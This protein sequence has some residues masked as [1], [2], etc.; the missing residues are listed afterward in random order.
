MG[1]IQLQF[2]SLV[3]KLSYIK[4]DLEYHRA[5]HI[6]RR[7]QFYDD[8]QEF[9]EDST[10]E[11]SEEKT[12]KNMIDVYKKR[13][14]V[15]AP[16]LLEEA[17][18]LYK[19]IAKQTHPDLY[20]DDMKNSVFLEASKA[21]DS[22]DWHTIYEIS[23]NLGVTLPNPSKEHVAWLKQEIQKIQS[24]IETI[25]TTFEWKYCMEGANKQ[26]LLTT[27]CMITCNVKKVNKK[28]P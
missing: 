1:A 24:L 26:Q 23:S 25:T 7:Q 21:M 9:M 10:F 14:Q 5:E 19:Q 13:E 16:N 28:Q 20:D 27:Y 8:L 2:K 11:Y 18:K 4:S 12:T 6:S 22:G 17:K 3:K 15:K